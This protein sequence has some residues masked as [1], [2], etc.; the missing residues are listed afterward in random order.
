MSCE[1]PLTVE[2]FHSK[3]PPAPIVKEDKDSIWWSSHWNIQPGDYVR[4]AR[5]RFK[6][7]G[8]PWRVIAI[9]Y[10]D[11]FS[12]TR[13]L[14]METPTKNTSVSPTV[15]RYWSHGLNEH[16][17]QVIRRIMH[18]TNVRLVDPEEIPEEEKEK[19]MCGCRRGHCY[20]DT[21]TLEYEVNEHSSTIDVSKGYRRIRL[22]LEECAE[23]ASFLGSAKTKIKEA[24]LAALKEQ[25]DELAKQLK[26]VEAM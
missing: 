19:D 16:G 5:G 2:Y 8:K 20:C 14:L 22:S 25:Q 17:E 11:R 1:N 26:E 18:A 7:I 12:S 3:H 6:H 23:L 21:A 15:D 10:R 9:G 13:M 24:K 4:S